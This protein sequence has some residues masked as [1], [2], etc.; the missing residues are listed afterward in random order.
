[1][2]ARAPKRSSQ[3]TGN[4]GLYLVCYELSRRGWNVMPTSRNARGVDIVG[5]SQ[6]GRRTITVQVKALTKRS[7]VPMGSGPKSLI[8]DFFIVAR[9]VWSDAATVFIARPTELVHL[10]HIGQK[11]GKHSYW[12]QPKDYEGFEGRW[13]LIGSGEEITAAIQRP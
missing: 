13:E 11:D 12:L 4:V 10:I 8:A 1:M 2:K 3:L 6:D 9:G 7:P 5:Y